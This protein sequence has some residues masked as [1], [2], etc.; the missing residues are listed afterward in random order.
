MQ[1]RKPAK[2]AKKQKDDDEDDDFEGVRI[3][4]NQAVTL[5]FSLKYLVNFSKSST[6][7][8]KVQL[9]MSND[10]PLL[11]SVVLAVLWRV[12]DTAVGLVRVQP[13]PHPVLP[14]TQN[15]RRLGAPRARIP[16]LACCLISVA[17]RSCMFLSLW[18]IMPKIPEFIEI[19]A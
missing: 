12:A 5:T 19:T 16:S 14:R 6:L 4:M 3:E 8:K 13:G 2:K 18:E 17:T 9:M 15:R 10:V 11:V 1:S 7:S